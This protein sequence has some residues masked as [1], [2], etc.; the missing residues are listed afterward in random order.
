MDITTIATQQANLIMTP[1]QPILQLQRQQSIE[2]ITGGFQ[3]AITHTSTE[4]EK[5]NQGKRMRLN[6]TVST[7]TIMAGLES[8]ASQKP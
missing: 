7:D 3:R 4:T 2:E 1:G 6:S 5:S 8:R